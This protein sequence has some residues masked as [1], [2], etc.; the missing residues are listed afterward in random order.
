MTHVI[1]AL[2]DD[3]HVPYGVN[4]LWDLTA[5]IDLAVEASFVREIFSGVYASDFG[6]WNTNFGEVVRHQ[7]RVGGLKIR[8]LFK[9]VPE[10]AAHLAGRDI[11][12]IAKSTVFNHRPDGLCI[13]GLTAGVQTDSSVLKSVKQAVPDT[14]ALSILSFVSKMWSLSSRPRMMGS[15][16]HIQAKCGF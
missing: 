3:I 14:P 12:S 16:H 15:R 1:T 5:S 10:A 7:H 6:L 9:I 2:M 8:L 11:P 4:V 13:S